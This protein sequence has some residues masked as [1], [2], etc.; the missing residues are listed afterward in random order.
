MYLGNVYFPG[1]H[2]LFNA[3]FPPKGIRVDLYA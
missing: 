3:I 2:V 1:F